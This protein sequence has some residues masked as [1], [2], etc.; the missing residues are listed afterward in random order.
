M[1]WSFCLTW[2][3]G[4][5]ILIRFFYFHLYISR[6]TSISEAVIICTCIYI[7]DLMVKQ[8]LIV[9][10]CFSPHTVLFSLYLITGI[11]MNFC[12]LPQF[13]MLCKKIKHQY[14]TMKFS[15]LPVGMQVI[16]WK[17]NVCVCVCVL[18]N[19]AGSPFCFCS[20]FKINFFISCKYHFYSLCLSRYM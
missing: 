4:L 11:L 16:T 15:A 6:N 12:L 9:I 18:E 8:S 10:Y 2:R 19:S 14:I 1:L 7:L 3:I 17:A 20:K 13:C 5:Q